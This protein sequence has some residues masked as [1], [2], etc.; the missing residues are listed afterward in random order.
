MKAGMSGYEQYEISAWSKTGHACEH[1]LNYWRYGDFLGIGAGAHAKFTDAGSGQI[2]RLSKHRHPKQYLSGDRMAENRLIDEGE[3][4]FEFF[5]NRLRLVEGLSPTEFS[6]RTG[7]RWKRVVDR[8]ALAMN[9]GLLEVRNERLVH[10]ETGWRF[11][12]DIQA[13]FLP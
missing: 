11:I 4:V 7:L 10:T 3:R 6:A 1:N 12:N 9:K 2:R 8:V 13:L 5:L